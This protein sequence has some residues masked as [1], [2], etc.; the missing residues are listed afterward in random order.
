MNSRPFIIAIEGLPR[1][2]KSTHTELLQNSMIR[3]TY[4]SIIMR[5]HGA[6]L[7]NERNNYFQYSDENWRHI[8]QRLTKTK[9]N[10]DEWYN[11]WNSANK[12]T[13]KE[14]EYATALLEYAN[15]ALGKKN[16]CDIVILNRCVVS[17]I[18]FSFQYTGEIDISIFDKATKPDL[19]IVLDC[20]QEILLKRLMED[21][22]NKKSFRKKIVSEYYD[23]FL[24]IVELLNCKE[25]TRFVKISTNHDISS[26]SKE[27]LKV[28]SSRMSLKG[29]SC[30]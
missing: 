25:K 13:L 29:T 10:T 28:V 9:M 4:N 1:S 8:H 22:S 11:L 12:K 21:T 6:G 23:D 30:E 3:D 19:V 24:N 26:V 17:E 14:V 16:L 7:G 27:L 2:G 18:F 20:P 15:R 5:G